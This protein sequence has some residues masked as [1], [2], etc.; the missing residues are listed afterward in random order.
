MKKIP[1]E[2]KIGVLLIITVII[3][4]SAGFLTYR[5]MSSMV[6]IYSKTVQARYESC[7]PEGYLFQSDGC[8]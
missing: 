7:K 8:G 2:L 1:L 3:M 6:I 4:I 5:N